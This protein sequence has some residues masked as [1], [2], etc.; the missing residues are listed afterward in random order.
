MA[1]VEESI[2][3]ADGNPDLGLVRTSIGALFFFASYGLLM[4]AFPAELAS[5]NFGPGY[6]GMV[7]GFH[8]LGAV[9]FRI[10]A[11]NAI[12]RMGARKI[13]AFASLAG[14]FATLLLGTTMMLFNAALP[15]LAVAKFV[16]G[17]AASAFLTSG[18][19]Y[20][21]QA[22]EPDKRGKRIGVYGSIGSFGLLVPPPVGIWLWLHSGS[23]YFWLLPVALALP[24][25]FLLPGDQRRPAQIAETDISDRTFGLLLS[26]AV[27][28]PVLALAV[29]AGM[30]GGFEA[31]L[32]RFVIEFNAQPIIVHLY[33]L[34]GLSVAAGRLGGGW[35]VD[36][37][38]AN[39]VFFAGLASQMFAVLLPLTTPTAIGLVSSAT[40]FGVGSGMV[41]TSAIALLAVSVPSHRSA[42]AIG[43]GGLL[44]DAG[45][46]TG[47]A[48]TG[49]A[50][51][52]GGAAAF[53]LG[54]LTATA[55]TVAIAAYLYRSKNHS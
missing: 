46:A 23:D 48:L 5:R 16:H 43:L 49:Q 53:L 31:H 7:V 51:A 50:I 42:A 55:M 40:V 9:C 36:R 24:A 33:V 14:V 20:V 8:A 45:F 47:A 35:L 39:V 44:K 41:T 12:D 30:Q 18:Y 37:N 1:L 15:M 2:A 19:A 25:L 52:F 10:V 21:T 6:I 17:A 34:F 11:P 3:H 22:G 38:G 32:P 26:H 28:A 27:F 13:A 29:S 54:G 4:G